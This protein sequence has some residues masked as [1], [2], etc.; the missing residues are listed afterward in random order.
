MRLIA[1]PRRPR[2]PEPK[3]WTHYAL[4]PPGDEELTDWM[5]RKLRIA[6]WSAPTGTVLQPIETAVMRHWLPPLNLVGVRTPWTLQVKTARTAM[7][8]QA[9]AWAS[10]RGFDVSAA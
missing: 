9:Q 4:E 1:T 8:I 2:D 6:V 7:A 5:Q 3:K 10:A